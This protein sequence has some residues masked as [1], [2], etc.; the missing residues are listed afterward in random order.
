MKPA[1]QCAS[2]R[3]LSCGSVLLCPV[4]AK[5]FRLRP[6]LRRSCTTRR[7]LPWQPQKLTIINRPMRLLRSP[8]LTL[9]HA[10]RSRIV[11]STCCRCVASRGLARATA[12]TSIIIAKVLGQTNA[13]LS[14]IDHIRWWCLHSFWSILSSHF[15]IYGLRRC[16][17]IL[18]ST[19]FSIWQLQPATPGPFEEK[20]PGSTRR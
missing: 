9:Y 6:R 10:R 16:C 13:G 12:T 7:D 14:M 15:C 8:S 4:K 2:R 11:D 17:S 1:R 18:V 19:V 3:V 20:P 5:S